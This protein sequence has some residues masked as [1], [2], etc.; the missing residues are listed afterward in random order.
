MLVIASSVNE[1]RQAIAAKQHTVAVLELQPVRV[2]LDIL[3]RSVKRVRE[4]V[5][6][7]REG[8]MV[9][10]ELTG[11]DEQRRRTYGLV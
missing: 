10:R 6:M 9:G 8:E 2:H 5:T 3:A 1:V 4:N 11:A 7:T